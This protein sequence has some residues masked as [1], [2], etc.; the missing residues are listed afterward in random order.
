MPTFK[1]EHLNDEIP[2]EFDSEGANTD[3]DE[4]VAPVATKKNAQAVD[5]MSNVSPLLIAPMVP[6]VTNLPVCSVGPL[7]KVSKPP[8]GTTIW[9]L[10][11]KS[12][13]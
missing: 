13:L 3:D 1:G 7:Q 8:A 6:S 10:P 5:T 9:Y 2:D 4:A 12:V 11:P